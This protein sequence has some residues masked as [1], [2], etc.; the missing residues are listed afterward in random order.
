MKSERTRRSVSLCVFCCFAV[1]V[2]AGMH[3]RPLLGQDQ[4][5]LR[6]LLDGRDGITYVLVRIGP[7]VWMAENLRFRTAAGSWCYDDDETKCEEYGALYDWNTAL[8]ACPAGWHLPSDEEWSDLES[9]LGTQ[10]GPKLREGGSSGFNAKMAGYRFY[11]G[12]Y[13]RQGLSTSYWSSTPFAADHSD[14]SL[15]RTLSAEGTEI[16]R[17]GYGKQGAVSVRCL[18]DGPTS[19]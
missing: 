14:H 2:A 12:S 4:T 7:E 18:W 6:P 16:Y 11:D 15:E 10:P 5:R 8:T 3:S 17:D 13:H 9:H 19:R 1:S